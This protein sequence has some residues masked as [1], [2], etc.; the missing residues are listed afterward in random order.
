MGNNTIAP[1]LQ[2]NDDIAKFDKENFEKRYVKITNDGYK[3]I[4]LIIE[5]IH[6]AACIWLNEKI[7]YDTDGIIDVNINYSNNKATIVWDGDI[8]SLSQIILKIRS[9]GYNAYPYDRSENEQLATKNKK[10]YFLKM[11][12]AVVASLNIMMIGVAKY[13]GF[14][15]GMDDEILNAIHIAEFFIATPTL[16]YSGSI[17]FKG[18]YFGLKN[19]IINMDF[20][21]SFGATLTYIYSIYVM[22]GGVGHSYFDSVVMIITFILV[23]KYLE[24]IGKK[25]A[26]DT[27]DTIKSQVPLDTIIIK[28]GV[29]VSVG[30]DEINQGDIIELKAGEKVSVDGEIISGSALFDQS[31]ISGESLPIYKKVGD[32]II[33][34]T[35]NTNSSIRYKTTTDFE[36]STLN[37][38]VTLVED[39]LSK[40]PDIENKANE[41]SKYFS[42]TILSIALFTFFGWYFYI[43]QFENALI[44]AISVIVIACPC[45]LALATP[46]ASLIGINLLA[47]KKLLFKESKHLETMA[48]ASV[49]VFD[50]TG[51]LTQGKLK[52]INKNIDLN[53]EQLNIL[54]SIVSSSLH[55]ISVAI[56]NYLEQNYTDLKELKLEDIVQIDAKGLKASCNGKII[57]GGN[58]E[59][60]KDEDIT[61]DEDFDT[62]IYH[63]SIENKHIITLKLEDNL[64]DDAS[65]IIKYLQKE[66]IEVVMCSGDNEKVVKKIANQIDIKNYHSNMTPSDKLNYI[67]KLKKEDKIVVMVGD[68][69]NDAP[70]L[71]L[72]DISIVM[73][74]GA[75]TAIDISDIVILD[76][77]LDGLKQSFIISKLTYKF[78][79]QNLSLSLIYNILTIPLAV[80]GFVIPLI[81]ALSMS[82]SSLIVVGNSLR[83]KKAKGD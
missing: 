5:G 37:N 27:I 44:N 81:A 12:I 42:I 79:K 13:T 18:A 58:K 32:K 17:F 28:D 9:I 22:L 45:A 78:I 38:I 41:L 52:I 4:H 72:S 11:M 75:D 66:N 59:L 60:F 30:I 15:T 23:G 73:G 35:I 48:K 67:Q 7:L 47:S 54:Y 76:N 53:N 16:F 74:S 68:G 49:V 6:C 61:I 69:I 20:L 65:K 33:G 3:K 51:T 26:V 62:T 1:P 46:M 8:L 83:I 10:T 39:S 50:K 36:H 63:F 70:A 64:K 57:L 43:G 25:T 80:F 55:P 24:V 19:K 2:T 71:A 31:N 21:V 56:K 34:G 29:K 77:S 14:F 82:L 40:K